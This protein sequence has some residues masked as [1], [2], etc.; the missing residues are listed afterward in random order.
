MTAQTSLLAPEW[1]AAERHAVAILNAL[2]WTRRRTGK[3]GARLVCLPALLRRYLLRPPRKPS[4][5]H[6]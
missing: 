4:D 2:G 5:L 1:N 6:S 3:A